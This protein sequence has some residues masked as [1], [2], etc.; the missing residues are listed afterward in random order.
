MSSKHVQDGRSRIL[1]ILK[2]TS[3]MV[4]KRTL[5]HFGLESL[6]IIIMIFNIIVIDTSVPPDKGLLKVHEVFQSAKVRSA[7]S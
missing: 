4:G 5:L 6:R 3:L 7:V 1:S 2:K